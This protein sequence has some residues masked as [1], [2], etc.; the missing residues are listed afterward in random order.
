MGGQ[1]KQQNP[2]IKAS[3]ECSKNS[4]M[5][6]NLLT[7]KAA[8]EDVESSGNKNPSAWYQVSGLLHF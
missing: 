2:N 3:Q 1:E 6:S 7:E 5:Y 8:N 4:E